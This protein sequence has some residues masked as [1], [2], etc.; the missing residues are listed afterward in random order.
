M[1]KI[2][3]GKFVAT[4]MKQELKEYID[5]HNI[6]ASLTI[7]QVGD[8]PASNVY[9]RN[10]QKACEEVGISSKVVKYDDVFDLQTDI[11]TYNRHPVMVQLPLTEGCDEQ[12]VLNMIN[13]RLDADCLTTSNLGKLFVGNHKFA[14]CTA[15]G[16]IDLLDYYDIPIE[17]KNAVVI[18][19]SNIVGKPISLLLLERNA[20]VTIC[21]S[22]TEH[23][24]EHTKNADILIVAIGKPKFI[25]ADMVKENSVV[26][27]V[28]INRDE[29]GKLC[30]DVD[31]ESVEPKV[32][33][34]SP[35]P[36]GV[37]AMTVVELLKNTLILD[38][39]YKN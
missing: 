9:I 10:K 15:Q 13:S 4:K 28:G 30:G 38:D 25:T 29:N 22:K 5:K 8:N 36:N 6:D 27:D 2:L 16:I 31:F 3:D 37:G 21:H 32:G 24:I 39:K 14:P 34:I 20:T 35:V 19:R 1:A 26:V 18:G 11:L 23:L 7:L 12:T 33:W 17:G